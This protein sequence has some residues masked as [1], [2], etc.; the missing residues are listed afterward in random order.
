MNGVHFNYTN[1]APY[2]A[3]YRKGREI[4]TGTQGLWQQR[5]GFKTTCKMEFKGGGTQEK[6]VNMKSEAAE[7]TVLK[8]DQIKET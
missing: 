5:K 1:A 4:K 6:Q 2:V 8:Q 7:E 3:H